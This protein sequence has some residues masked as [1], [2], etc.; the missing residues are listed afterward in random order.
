MA[1]IAWIRLAKAKQEAA[2]VHKASSVW[3]G[4]KTNAPAEQPAK[5]PH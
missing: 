3:E 4:V 2:D 5:N 1:G